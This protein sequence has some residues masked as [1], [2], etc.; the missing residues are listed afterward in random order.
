MNYF[1][2]PTTLMRTSPG[3]SIVGYD[4]TTKV[5][6]FTQTTVDTKLGE[7][8]ISTNK[9]DLKKMSKDDLVEHIQYQ[10]LH[11]HALSE[12]RNMLWVLLN[13]AEASRTLVTLQLE[14]LADD[15]DDLKHEH[16][17]LRQ[18]ASSLRQRLEVRMRSARSPRQDTFDSTTDDPRRDERRG[19]RREPLRRL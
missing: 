15:K 7:E 3:S 6:S 16:S 13:K 10:I 11:H 2:R 12:Q 4:A 17:Q 5:R 1:M 9:D 19:E 8:Q 18:E 14:E